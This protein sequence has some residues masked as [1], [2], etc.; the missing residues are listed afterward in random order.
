MCTRRYYRRRASCGTEPAPLYHS[1]YSAIGIYLY[2]ICARLRVSLLNRNFALFS[3]AAHNGHFISLATHTPIASETLRCA[4]I[5]RR[6]HQ[7]GQNRPMNKPYYM[8]SESFVVIPRL[9]GPFG[10]GWSIFAPVPVFNYQRQFQFF[11]FVH[12]VSAVDERRLC[13]FTATL[14]ALHTHHHHMRP[15]APNENPYKF[16]CTHVVTHLESAPIRY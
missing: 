2:Y 16:T 7:R 9:F 12:F 10:A 15:H 5:A 14:P 1:P 8:V 4:H 6:R 3:V 13:S 11:R